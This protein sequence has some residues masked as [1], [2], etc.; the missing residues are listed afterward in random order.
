M[1]SP[2]P[3]RGPRATDFDDRHAGGRAAVH[4]A[5]HPG[6]V[7]EAVAAL[8][9]RVTFSE[10]IADFPTA[11]SAAL[12]AWLSQGD[13]GEQ[14]ARITK[15][16]GALAGEA[17]SIDRTD[18]LRVTFASGDIIHLRPS[19]NAPELRCYTEGAQ[20]ARAQMLNAEALTVV[21]GALLRDM[22]ADAGG[23]VLSEH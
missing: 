20:A 6:R 10:R 16:F 2:R 4:L 9:P 13:A 12:L 22:R 7:A 3:E 15:Y 14:L 11:D 17:Q 19:G 23:A 5:K 21:Q 8:P 18:G 1:R